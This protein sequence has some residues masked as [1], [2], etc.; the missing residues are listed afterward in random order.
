MLRI[1]ENFRWI[2]PIHAPDAPGFVFIGGE[3]HASDFGHP[4][5]QWPSAQLSGKGC[6]EQEALQGCIGEGVEHLSRLEWGGE[7]IARGCAGELPHGHSAQTSHEILRLLDLDSEDG[8][9]ELSWMEGVRLRDQARILLPVDLCL[10]RLRRDTGDTPPSAISTGCAAGQTKEAATLSALLELVERDAAAM[11]WRGR[12]RGRAISMETLANSGG[13]AL[14]GDLRQGNSD[15]RTWLLDITTDVDIC[16]IVAISVNADG[17]GF[18][19]GIAAHLDVARAIRGALLELCQIELG[20][21]LVAAKREVRGDAALNDSDRRKLERSEKI[22]ADCCD[23]LRPDTPAHNRQVTQEFDVPDAIEK[24][25]EGITRIGSEPLL[26]DLTRPEIGIPA[27]RAVAPGLQP[28]P[29]KVETARLARQMSG[30]ES[31]DRASEYIP[32]F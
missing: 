15:R 25:I 20:H 18:A 19:T 7:I 22:S 9:T 11:W 1:A 26:V 10:R 6:S 2:S 17:K 3:L 29:S 28:F 24:V 4:E 13:A 23:L 30:L 12:R 32:L 21:R 16:C 14:L 31:T 5:T 8:T 27:V